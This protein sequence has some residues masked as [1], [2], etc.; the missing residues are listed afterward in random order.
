MHEVIPILELLET[1]L[2]KVRDSSDLP[3]IIRVAAIAA[4]LVVGKYYALTDESEVY[5]IAISKEWFE[6]FAN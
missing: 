3:D 4:L 5:H 6:S 2:T 1:D